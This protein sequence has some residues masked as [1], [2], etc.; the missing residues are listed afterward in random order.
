FNTLKV[1]EQTRAH[2]DFN[3]VVFPRFEQMGR[4]EAF[5]LLYRKTLCGCRRRYGNITRD[6][7]ARVDHEMRII[8]EKNFAHYFLVVADTAGRAQRS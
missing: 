1:A 7:R 5:Q 4:E 8:R 6:V 2:W 3:R